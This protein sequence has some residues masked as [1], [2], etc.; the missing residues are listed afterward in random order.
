M[1]NLVFP[2]PDIPLTKCPHCG[3]ETKITP[4]WFEAIK[5]LLKLVNAGL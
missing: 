1:A 2:T 3:A 4:V 5:R